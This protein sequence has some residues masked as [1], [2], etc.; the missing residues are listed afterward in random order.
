[1]FEDMHFVYAGLGAA[2]A[3]VSCI[4]IMLSMM[5]FATLD[6]SRASTRIRSSSTRAC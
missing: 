6:Q 4:V 5:R 1:M 3:T 2:G